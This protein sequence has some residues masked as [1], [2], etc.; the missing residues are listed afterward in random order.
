MADKKVHHF[1]WRDFKLAI[2]D[3]VVAF[4]SS[5]RTVAYEVYIYS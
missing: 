5:V 2:A 3:F 4:E 1:D